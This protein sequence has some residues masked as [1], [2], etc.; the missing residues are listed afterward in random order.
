VIKGVSLENVLPRWDMVVKR[1]ALCVP[2]AKHHMLLVMAWAQRRG[3]GLR[4]G[5]ANFFEIFEDLNRLFERASCG[6]RLPR[7]SLL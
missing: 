1:T 6:R 5:P 3:V 2:I 7:A 4:G